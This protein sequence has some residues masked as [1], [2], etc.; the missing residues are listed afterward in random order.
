M[1]SCQTNFTNDEV[2]NSN[3]DAKAGMEVGYSHCQPLCIV[4]GHHQFCMVMGCSQSI[5]L[6]VAR[7]DILNLDYDFDTLFGWKGEA[8]IF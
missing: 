2:N 7:A 4:Q 8:C 3:K 1:N 5:E 6:T